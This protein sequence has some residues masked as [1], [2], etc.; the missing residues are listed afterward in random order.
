MVHRPLVAELPANSTGSDTLLRRLTPCDQTA[1]KQLRAAFDEP[2]PAAFL[3]GEGRARCGRVL[4]HFLADFDDQTS[5]V[6]ITEPCTDTTSC[7]RNVID[8]IGL[9]TKDFCLKDLDNIFGM[10]LYFQRTHSRRTVV[11]VENAQDCSSW[12]LNK[13]FELTELEAQERF[14]LFVVLAGRAE[15]TQRLDENAHPGMV[16]YARRQIAVS[17]LK[18]ADT[19]EFV[20]QQ[21]K[22]AGFD[23]VSQVIEFEA[24]TL[25]HEITAGVPDAINELCDQSLSMAA[26]SSVYPISAEAVDRAAAALGLIVD[27][28]SQ[29]VEQDGTV[30]PFVR[31]TDRFIVRMRGKRHGEHDLDND[32][33]SI[34]RDAQNDLCVPSLL[35]SRH[36]ALIVKGNEGVNVM[37]LGSTN[38][39]YVN[40]EK[41]SSHVLKYGDKIVIG[42][43]QIEYAA[44]DSI[45]DAIVAAEILGSR[46]ASGP[47]IDIQSRKN[48]F[49]TRFLATDRT[50]HHAGFG[51][52]VAKSPV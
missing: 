10:F 37:D 40:G 36:H 1:L 33:F 42:D 5:V 27:S 21:I 48:H 6:R 43:C 52:T 24:I 20:R 30:V 41:V 47:I 23:D 4:D 9:E 49:A 50:P 11:C 15:L 35:V 3:I 17:P 22:A 45:M 34:G 25:L 18:A 19:R 16:A 14:G 44:A 8:S 31:E 51:L 28:L 46:P 32:C 29:T 7:M 2:S 26:A 39:T 12:V 38:G 13:I